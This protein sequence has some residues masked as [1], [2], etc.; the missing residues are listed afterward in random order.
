MSQSKQPLTISRRRLLKLAAVAPAAGLIN[1]GELS[2][3]IAA[4]L[5]EGGRPIKGYDPK[6]LPDATQLGKWLQQL[7]D[8]GPIRATGTKQARAFEEWLAEQVTSLGFELK[9][10]QFKLTSWECDIEK[11]CAISV[12][13]EGGAK[14][15]VEVVAYYP[16]CGSTRGKAPISGTVLYVPNGNQ[17]AAASAF[18]EKTDP[19]LLA[20][21]IVVID[22]PL[23]GGR[24][25]GASGGRARGGTSNNVAAPAESFPAS[26]PGGGG[27]P[28]PAGQGGRA[29]MQQ[30]EDKC[31]ALILCNSNIANDTGRYNYLPFSDQH[32]KIPCLFVGGDGSKYL[33]SISGTKAVLTLRCDALLTPDAR[34][35]SLAG[36]M[37]GKTDEVIFITTHTDGPNE[38][39]D[40]GAL[41]V[42]ALAT[43]WSRMPKDNRNRTLF[44]S[45]PTGHYAG[46]AVRQGG[47][48]QRSGTGG[49]MAQYP[50]V[51]RRTVA[52]LHLEQMGAMEWV[53]RDGKY[54][55]TGNVA[56]ERW[57]PTPASADVWRRLFLA[58]S[59]TEDPKFANAR[60]VSGGA[61]RRRRPAKPRHPRYWP[62]G[63]AVVLLPRRPQGRAR[64]AEPKRDALRVIRGR[65]VNGADEPPHRRSDER[66][67]GDQGLR[68]LRVILQP[69]NCFR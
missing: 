36:T 29:Q 66:Q 24:S 53:D 10:T 20:E 46:G 9:R 35:D 43:Y 32:R 65:Q 18:I 13:E 41:G 47:N 6:L 7:H 55:P 39:N 54:V 27:G 38:V 8:F 37:N 30:F 11:D 61:G 48:A 44:L 14:K 21:S 57:I 67:G 60:L 26:P 64:Q 58:A 22:M 28:N 23:G 34:T 56:P 19:K 62:D 59:E 12:V 40:N 31:K 51:V 15:N 49:I 63:R 3:A 16:F 2:P 33:Q 52:Q 5:A 45:L 25:S 17:A 42:L 69:N 68:H 4:L 1:I 50:D